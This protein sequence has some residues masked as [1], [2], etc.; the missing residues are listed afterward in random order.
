MVERNGK[1]KVNE[2]TAFRF[3][4]VD[5]TV[6]GKLAAIRE[7]TLGIGVYDIKT[8]DGA[9]TVFGTKVLEGK[10]QNT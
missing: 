5:E 6:D 2:S 8:K 9:V 1:S 3:E 10:N 4:K 7:G